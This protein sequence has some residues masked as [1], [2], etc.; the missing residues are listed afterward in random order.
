MSDSAVEI[1]FS[2]ILMMEFIRQTTVA[3]CLAGESVDIA[4]RFKVE[5]AD[6]A[7]GFGYL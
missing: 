5:A 1:P 4:V 3:R 2:P 7:E 6:T